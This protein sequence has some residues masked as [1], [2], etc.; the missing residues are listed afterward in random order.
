VTRKIGTAVAVLVALGLGWQAYRNGRVPHPVD[1]TARDVA[2]REISTCSGPEPSSI[3]TTAFV[4]TYVFP[5]A[6]GDVKVE[7]RWSMLLFGSVRCRGKLIRDAAPVV[8]DEQYPDE[9]RR[10]AP[11]T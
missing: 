9:I 10:G 3:E 5:A 4:R 2:C 11:G 1:G 8:T 6:D 7:C